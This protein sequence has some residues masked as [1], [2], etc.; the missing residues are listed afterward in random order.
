SL[1]GS[2]YPGEIEWR[3]EKD[4]DTGDTVRQEARVTGR[5]GKAISLSYTKHDRLAFRS[6]LVIG[7]PK[8]TPNDVTYTLFAYGPSVPDIW[9]PARRISTDDMNVISYRKVACRDDIDRKVVFRADQKAWSEGWRLAR[10]R[11]SP[12]DLKRLDDWDAL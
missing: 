4:L 2:F 7:T 9:G 11:V 5:P 6:T 3:S 10:E 8:V 12:E 1:K